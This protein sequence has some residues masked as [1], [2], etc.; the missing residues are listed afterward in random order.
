MIPIDP[1]TPTQR[2]QIK[3]HSHDLQSW[4]QSAAMLPSSTQPVIG[5]T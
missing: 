4:L 3:H 2:R 1:D 5:M